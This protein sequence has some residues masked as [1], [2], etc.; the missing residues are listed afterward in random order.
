MR[1]ANEY[2]LL[3]TSTKLTISKAFELL[4]LPQDKR[5]EFLEQNDVEG[6]TTKKE[7]NE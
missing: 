7:G 2:P 5:E 6:M 1:V 3:S 4:C